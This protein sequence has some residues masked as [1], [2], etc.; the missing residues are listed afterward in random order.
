MKHILNRNIKDILYTVILSVFIVCVMFITLDIFQDSVILTKWYAFLIGSSVFG[1]LMLCSRT[2]FCIFS[3]KITLCLL[4]FLSYLLIRNINLYLGINSLYSPLAFFVLFLCFRNLS[5]KL[6]NRIVIVIVVLCFSQSIYGILQYCEV[7]NNYSRFKVVGSYD[8]PSG[9][10]ACL[11]AS[12]PY[13]FSFFNTKKPILLFTGVIISILI[14][15][16][17]ILSGSRSGILSII[18]VSMLYCGY[19]RFFCCSKLIKQVWLCSGMFVLIAIGIILF[20]IKK[21]SAVGRIL[22]WSNT[23]ELINDRPL[24]GYGPCGFTANYMSAQA[25]YFEN[26]SESIYSQLADNIIM[27][28]NDYLFIAVKYGIIGL[29][30]CL[31]VAYF[32]FKESDKLELGH[33][34][35]ISIGVFACFSYPLRY[36]YVLFLLAYSIAI[37]SKKIGM[38]NLNIM[39]KT[40]LTG[41]LIIGMYMLCLDIRFESKWNILV[42]MSVLGKTRTLIPEYNKLYKIWNYNPSFLYNYAAV[43]NKASDFR[44]SNAVIKECIKYVNDYDIQILLANNYYNLND[45]SLAEKYYMNASNMCPNRFIP[46]YGLFLVNQKRG[47]QKKCYELA[48]L[49]LNKPI[50]T[51]SSTIKNIKREVYVFNKSKKAINRLDER[52]EEN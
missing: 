6:N 33:F 45:L 39:V 27:P 5:T 47:D 24:L 4:I 18:I 52:N 30:M 36:P 16:A 48:S 40:L 49:I 9:F 29:L 17:I 10:A 28:F 13:C 12:F 26:N 51:M 32:V 23:L 35:I 19:K 41:I 7:F 11:S 46:L 8:N 14:I 34:C 3:D 25:V 22:I 31:V 42:E 38:H 21:D 20:V 37:S 43:L 44:T 2:V 15:I 1:I 50:K